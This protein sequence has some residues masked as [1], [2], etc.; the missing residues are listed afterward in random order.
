[1]KDI[2]CILGFHDWVRSDLQV[3]FHPQ[4][5]NLRAKESYAEQCSHCDRWRLTTKLE[6]IK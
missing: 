1:M 3:N 4:D 2:R 6:E 5:M